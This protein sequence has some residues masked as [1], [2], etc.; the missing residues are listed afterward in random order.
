[1]RFFNADNRFWRLIILTA[2]IL[3]L[4][5]LW[6]IL[7]LTVVG[8]GPA[9]TALYYAIAKSIRRERGRPFQEFFHA[10]KQNWWKSMIVGL[11]LE[12]I[13][14]GLMMM[15]FTVLAEPFLT[16]DISDDP[17]FFWAIL[18]LVLL[19]I[20]SMHIFPVLSRFQTTLPKAAMLSILLSFRHLGKTLMLSL[21]FLILFVVSIFFPVLSLI[22]PGL[23]TYFHS[24]REEKPNSLGWD[25]KSVSM[26]P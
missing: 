23:F 9:S 8:F 19:L 21:V 11:V 13:M 14:A 18:H 10:L 6:T 26:V 25:S 17:S 12:L 2:D 16:G 3:L 1:M 7:T 15:D 4:G 22:A 24:F 5:L 20:F